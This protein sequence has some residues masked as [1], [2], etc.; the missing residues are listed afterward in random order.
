MQKGWISNTEQKPWFVWLS[1]VGVILQRTRSPGRFPVRVQA[2]IVGS[3][4]GQGA[5]KKQLIDVS[6]P[7]S[8]PFPLSE[9]K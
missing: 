5:Y 9:N 4:P 6:L 7:L 2:W 8:L 3:V 1:W